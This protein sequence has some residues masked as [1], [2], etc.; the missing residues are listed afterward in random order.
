MDI[1]QINIA[2]VTIIVVYLT[3]T[4]ALTKFFIKKEK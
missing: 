4:V 1:T 2:H 3:D